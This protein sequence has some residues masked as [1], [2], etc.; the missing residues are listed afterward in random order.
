MGRGLIGPDLLGG[1]LLF[2][3]DKVGLQDRVDG[4]PT[5]GRDL[6]DEEPIQVRR[7]LELR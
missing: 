6:P 1:E 3:A 4:T 5:G 2:L 7:R